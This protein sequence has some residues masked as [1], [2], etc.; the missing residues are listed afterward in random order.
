VSDG[1]RTWL[2]PA[3]EARVCPGSHRKR[4]EEDER[5]RMSE[6][7]RIS[8]ITAPALKMLMFLAVVSTIVPACA[9]L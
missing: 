8:N 5:K 1:V 4:A 2:P 6:Q 9:E 7:K 3:Q